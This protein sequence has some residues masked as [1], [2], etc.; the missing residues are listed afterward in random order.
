MPVLGGLGL[1][2]VEGCREVSLHLFHQSLTPAG[3]WCPALSSV[4]WHL[5]TGLS[6]DFLEEYK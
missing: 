4:L 5:N 6:L 3:L 2:D 1:E